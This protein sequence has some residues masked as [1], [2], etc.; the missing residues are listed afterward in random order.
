[1]KYFVLILTL[2]SIDLSWQWSWDSNAKGPDGIA[3]GRPT[4]IAHRGSSG[5]YP[6]HT[7]LA[8]R[9]AGEQGTDFVECDVTITKVNFK[10][11]VI[12]V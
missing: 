9:K 8:Y 6:E 1:M 3:S 5:M 11:L 2:A 12:A 4:K 10:Y 7:M